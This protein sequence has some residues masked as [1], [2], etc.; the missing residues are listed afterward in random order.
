MGKGVLIPGKRDP[1]TAARTDRQTDTDGAVP[2]PWR[3]GPWLS[4]AGAQRAAAA[5][6]AAGRR[7]RAEPSR[8]AGTTGARRENPAPSGDPEPPGS[9]TVRNPEGSEGPARSE[10]P[11]PSG[12]PHPRGSWSHQGP[13]PCAAP[14]PAQP[15]S[16]R[17]PAPA[18]SRSLRIPAPSGAPFPPGPAP[19]PAGPASLTQ[20]GPAG[21]RPQQRQRHVRSKGTAPGH[22][23][24]P[25]LPP[26]LPP[27]GQRHGRERPRGAP[28][29]GCE[30]QRQRCWDLGDEPSAVRAGRPWHSCPQELWLPH[31]WKRPRTGWSIL[32]EGVV[33]RELQYL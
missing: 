27:P 29:G 28:R 17:G 6:S 21:P 3:G 9:R 20:S 32:L 10:G 12:V 22:G 8:A 5:P 14:L 11:A 4:R 33:L 16:L 31:A 18:G 7:S 1:G 25:E 13:A 30:R 19:R 24:A 23:T 26:P 2:C 15:C